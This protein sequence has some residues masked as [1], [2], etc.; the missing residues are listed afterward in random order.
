MSAPSRPLAGPNGSAGR[1]VSYRGPVPPPTRPLSTLT[2]RAG[3]RLIC[4]TASGLLV[5]QA[6]PG[7]DVWWL[8]PVRV[9]LLSAAVLGTRWRLA[10]LL[11]LAHGLGF[12]LPTLS[13]SVVCVA[14]LPWLALA[15]LE[16]LYIGASCALTAA[17]QRPLLPSRLRPLAY[18]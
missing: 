14:N 6:F 16:A 10:V 4:A 7:H 15:P 1:S 9:G 12:F 18:A 11:G 17:V 3:I 13:W 2:L 5:A 8:A